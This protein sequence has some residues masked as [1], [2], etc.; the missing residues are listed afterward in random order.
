MNKSLTG[1]S[2]MTKSTVV[3][4]VCDLCNRKSVIE[5]NWIK[6]QRSDSLESQH[7]CPVCLSGAFLFD[8]EDND[9]KYSPLGYLRQHRRVDQIHST[10]REPD[11]MG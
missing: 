1:E 9:V 6:I 10:A 4:Y 5:G 8:P 2:E 3:Q 7:I 11:R